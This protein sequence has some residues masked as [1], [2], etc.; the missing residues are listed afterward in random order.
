MEGPKTK[1]KDIEGKMKRVRESLVIRWSHEGTWKNEEGT[2]RRRT[3]VKR[4]RFLSVCLWLNCR[5][6]LKLKLG[7]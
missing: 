7:L 1:T 5:R 3:Y 4:E 6:G 2:K